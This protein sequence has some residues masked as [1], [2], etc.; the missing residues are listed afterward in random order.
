MMFSV[1]NINCK[2]LVNDV[3]SVITNSMKYILYKEINGIDGT[4]DP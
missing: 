1:I 3:R 4:L 2:S